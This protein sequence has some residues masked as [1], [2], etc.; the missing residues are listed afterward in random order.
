MRNAK[1]SK[2]QTLRDYFR[3][4]EPGED[5]VSDAPF[6]GAAFEGALV[7]VMDRPAG[8]VAGSSHVKTAVI[9]EES[10]T[11]VI[12]GGASEIYRIEQPAKVGRKKDD[13]SFPAA[14]IL[15]LES[16]RRHW[17]VRRPSVRA[18]PAEHGLC[19]EARAAVGFEQVRADDRFIHDGLL[20]RQ[21]GPSIP[22]LS[23]ERQSKARCKAHG[24][25]VYR[26][27]VRSQFGHNRFEAAHHR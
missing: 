14:V 12:I 6:A 18:C 21:A 20:P 24:K 3:R 1:S 9:S 4:D 7:F 13:E 8:T 19:P 2:D 23:T 11:A 27:M 15:R 10:R 16:V 17:E 25:R 5:T 22:D 26:R